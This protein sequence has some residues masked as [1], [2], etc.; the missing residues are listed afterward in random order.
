[1]PTVVAAIWLPDGAIAASPTV[2]IKGL[3]ECHPPA[4]QQIEMDRWNDELA[5]PR[6]HFLA[7]EL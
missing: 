7:H 4:P 3:A 1:M 5:V 2:P 6:S